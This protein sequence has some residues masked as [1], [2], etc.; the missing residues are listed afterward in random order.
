MQGHVQTSHPSNISLLETAQH[1]LRNITLCRFGLDKVHRKIYYGSGSYVY[2]ISANGEDDQAYSQSTSSNHQYELVS[3]VKYDPITGAVWFY[4]NSTYQYIYVQYPD[5]TTPFMIETT[6]KTVYPGYMQGIFDF[7]VLNNTAYYTDQFAQSL[8]SCVMDRSISDNKCKMSLGGGTNEYDLLAIDLQSLKLYGTTPVNNVFRANYFDLAQFTVISSTIPVN[9]Y[10]TYIPDNCNGCSSNG[11]CIQP[12]STSYSSSSSSSPSSS[13]FSSSLS[14]T[15]YTCDCFPNF[16]QEDCNIYC[17]ESDTCN[18]HGYCNTNG[19]CV[20]NDNYYGGN[21]EI[22]CTFEECTQN[23]NCSANGNCDCNE[24]YSGVNC[25]VPIIFPTS[26]SL[27]SANVYVDNIY[28]IN[29]YN[30][31]YQINIYNYTTYIIFEDYVRAEGYNY[32]A[33]SCSIFTLQ[34]QSL[35]KIQPNSQSHLIYWNGTQS[36]C[37]NDNSICEWV[38]DVIFSSS[39]LIM[40]QNCNSP[41]QFVPSSYVDDENHSFIFDTSSFDF[42]PPLSVFKLPSYCS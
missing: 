38:N 3:G 21:C 37:V 19:Y 5:A 8:Y 16:Y 18:S 10:I 42:N 14:S 7:V 17:E 27:F 22:Y 25:T 40:Q 11:N 34:S 15:N 32:T 9:N 35:R 31:E 23:G 26:P 24:Y 13:S 30:Y 41:T 6:M 2:K 20:C 39:S 4:T 12:E 28:A 33:S 29:Y 36:E 1:L